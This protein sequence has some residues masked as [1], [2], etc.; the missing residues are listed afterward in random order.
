M[1][2]LT[3]NDNMDE[4][5]V[6]VDEAGKGCMIGRV[7]AA[8]V[9]WDSSKDANGIKDSKKISRK[10]RKLLKEYIE[11]NA[12][13]YG[14]GWATNEEINEINISNA[15]FKAMHRA[16]DGV[17][18]HFD[19]ILVDGNRFKPY[20]CNI[21]NCIIGGD[22]V[23]VNI[24]AASILAKEYHDEWIHTEFMDDTKYDLLNNKGYGT[25]KHIEGIKTYGV[26]PF[27]RT[28]YC[29]KYV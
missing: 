1:L 28:L 27:H 11:Q 10:N 29:S 14:V 25:K 17:N 4:V 2:S 22:D 9:I 20:K 19:R 6:G 26:T 5:T 16:L 24:A 13:A 8:A 12:L 23:Y 3:Y 18:H 15:T 7:Y 21:H